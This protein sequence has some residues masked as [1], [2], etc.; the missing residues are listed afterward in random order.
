MQ[1]RTATSAAVLLLTATTYGQNLDIGLNVRITDIG[2]SHVEPRIAAHPEDAH[3]LLVSGRHLGYV[4][5]V[6]ETFSISDAGAIAL[7][8]ATQHEKL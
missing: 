5:T 7:D 1:V 6:A 3:R 2:A 4:G 8:P